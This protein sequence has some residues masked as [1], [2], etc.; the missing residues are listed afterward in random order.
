[1]KLYMPSTAQGTRLRHISILAKRNIAG[2]TVPNIKKRSVLTFS[3]PTRLPLQQIATIVFYRKETGI[4]RHTRK[5]TQNGKIIK[6][7]QRSGVL[8]KELHEPCPQTRSSLP[9]VSLP[10]YHAK[11]HRLAHAQTISNH[12]KS[13]ADRLC[14]CKRPDKKKLSICN[15]ANQHKPTAAIA[16]G[17]DS[18][19]PEQNFRINVMW[20]N[21][22]DSFQHRPVVFSASCLV[23]SDIRT[24]DYKIIQHT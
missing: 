21:S 19:N 5:N 14:F 10:T 15:K 12:H 6:D 17:V 4:V 11:V 2:T 8:F 23:G 24:F 18:G 7:H 9:S 1:M 13:R 22:I 16:F 3:S 20:W